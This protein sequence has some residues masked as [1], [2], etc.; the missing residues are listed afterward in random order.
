MGDM[1]LMYYQ[2][3]EDTFQYLPKLPKGNLIEFGVFNGNTM[4]R[5]IKGAEA[6]NNP[7]VAV[8]GFDSFIGLPKET[9]GIYHN[10]DWPEGAFNVSKDFGLQSVDEAL[11]FVR[12][13]IDRKDIDLVPGFFSETLTP[14]L[15]GIFLNDF[16]YIHIDVDIYSSTFQVLDWL[17]SYKLIKH[18]AVVR[19][20][21]WIST[22]EYMGGN[23]LAHADAVRK[24]RV[25]FNRL[26]VNVFQ[27]LG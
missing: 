17:L 12:G 9:D 4:N 21:D 7:F 8:L 16:S 13:R 18:G 3:V 15:A 11:T 6:A 24:H 23:S 2:T 25:M 26:S 5:L 14:T 22:P 20:D 19:Y 27:Y 1:A 10:P